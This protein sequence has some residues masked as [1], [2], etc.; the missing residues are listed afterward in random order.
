M[1]QIRIRVL[2]GVLV[3]LM[4]LTYTLST[5]PAMAEQERVDRNT[6][7]VP[8]PSISNGQASA[9]GVPTPAQRPVTPA[10]T[11]PFVQRRNANAQAAAEY[12]AS[13]KASKQQMHASVEEAKARYKE[14]VANAKINRK[15][16]KDAAMNELKST[17]LERQRDNEVRQ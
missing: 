14:E 13:K 12:R 7:D 5:R 4:T 16:D 8:A 2:V 9:A 11:D 1:T 3:A 17:E 10:P 15:A 6:A